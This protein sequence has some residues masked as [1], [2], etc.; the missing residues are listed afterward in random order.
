[1]AKTLH[2]LTARQVMSL[3]D[4]KYPDG[5]GL[6]L[7]VQGNS[8]R[9]EF[10]NYRAPDGSGRRR[11]MGLGSAIMPEGVSLHDARV[12]AEKAR[13]L[14]KSKLD[15]LDARPQKRVPL[16]TAETPNTFGQVAKEF[17]H[18]R[19]AGWRSKVYVRQW[20]MTIEK[21][22]EGIANMP[23]DK[24]ETSHILATLNPLWRKIPKTAMALRGRIEMILDAAKV[25]GLRSGEN[26]ARW[27]GHI[28]L[29]LPARK[30]TD[31]KH[32]AALPY[33]EAPAF[34]RD[35]RKSG[36]IGALALEFTI[37]T[38]A[39]VGEALGATWGE[40]DLSKAVWQVPA[41][42]MKAG[43]QHKVPL[44]ARALA[45]L[46]SLPRGADTDY[47]FSIQ[48]GKQLDHSTMNKL[49]LRVKP[50][51]TIHGF[52]STFRDWCSEET[53]FS[54]HAAE[55]ALAHHVGSQVELAYRRRSLFDQRRQL[56]TA[57]CDY[58]STE[59]AAQIVSLVGRRRKR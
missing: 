55:E 31:V 39:R 37:L 54:H 43:R 40:M 34:M 38:C 13:A 51:I 14:L 28:A 33:E 48:P 57:W 17:I 12:A 29:V 20:S 18:T 25:K 30:S 47:V 56:M 41:Q 44:S 11:T 15:P 5:G 2:R 16:A 21:Y 46:A 58:L 59:G 26:P 6:R 22:C 1:M 4:G 8:R 53:S 49:L 3:P 32:L 27:K 23:V 24:I 36:A 45:I 9:W 35:L 19:S 10:F 7:V 50:G 42:R 52:R